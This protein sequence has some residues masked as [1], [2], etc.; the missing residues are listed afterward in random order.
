MH[1]TDNYGNKRSNY[2]WELHSWKL[3]SGHTQSSGS[4]KTKT[5]TVQKHTFTWPRNEQ[6]KQPG[7]YTNFAIMQYRDSALFLT[8]AETFIEESTAQKLQKYVLV[9]S[10]AIRQSA[11]QAGTAAT[12]HT[13]SILNQLRSGRTQNSAILQNHHRDN[14]AVHYAYSKK[15]R[16]KPAESARIDRTYQPRLTGYLSLRQAF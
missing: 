3:A 1:T 2:I 7:N 9:N 12:Q 6:Q 15:K 4:N 5:L 14:L 13:R 11:R 8:N 10:K 16:H